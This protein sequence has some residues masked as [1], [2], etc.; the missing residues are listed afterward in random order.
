MLEIIRRECVYLWYYF[1]VQL[2]QFFPYWVLGMLL[3]FAVSV[4]LKDK[5]YNIFRA[6][7]EKKIGILGIVA[8]SILGIA[9]P[10]CMYGTIPIV[11]SFSKGSIKD[12]WLAAF[13][14]SSILLNPQLILYSAALGTTGFGRADRVLL[15]VWYCC[16]SAG[17]YF[18]SK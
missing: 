9:S 1:N 15:C 13:M 6:I 3:G 16:Q 18:L 11:A 14:M 5:I 4:F 8:A 12:D 17:T 10:L 2:E 7:G